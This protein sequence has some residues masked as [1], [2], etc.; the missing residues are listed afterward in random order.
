MNTTTV[1]LTHI[2]QP[3]RTW[4]RIA[5]TML[6]WTIRSP[7]TR[8]T[9]QSM[10]GFLDMISV[11]LVLG[12]YDPVTQT[13]LRHLRSICTGNLVDASPRT[14]PLNAGTHTALIWE[15]ILESQR[16]SIWLQGSKMHGRNERSAELVTGTSSE[17]H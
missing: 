1:R 10:Q 3:W 16:W 11:L 2:T 15:W 5:H 6:Q 9:M 7:I 12:K 8:P 4:P 14:I 13:T 17:P